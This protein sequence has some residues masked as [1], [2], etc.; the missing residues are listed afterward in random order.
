MAARLFWRIAVPAATALAAVNA[1]D[2][3]DEHTHQEQ[4]SSASVS[5]DVSIPVSIL[6]ASLQHLLQH[7]WSNASAALLSNVPAK[8]LSPSLTLRIEEE[9]K[10]E[11]ARSMV[12]VRVI[13]RFIIISSHF[14]SNNIG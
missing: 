9:A 1:Q 5:S 10:A 12:E 14:I 7:N 6:Q 3:Q 11:V 13:K 8:I 4:A 2:V